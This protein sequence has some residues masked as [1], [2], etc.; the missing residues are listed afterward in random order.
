MGDMSIELCPWCTGALVER[1]CIVCGRAV[2]VDH[3]CSNVKES[4]LQDKLIEAENRV[5]ILTEA[6]K[7]ADS[8]FQSLDEAL[9]SPER[10]AEDTATV[11][12]FVS[13]LDSE[14]NDQIVA[15]AIGRIK[16]FAPEAGARLILPELSESNG[17]SGDDNET[18]ITSP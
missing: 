4:S 3:C 18:T 9:A 16:Q 7:V 6:L 10:I 12:R 13:G 8:L 17:P 15:R 11:G 5:K 1:T 14:S 2:P